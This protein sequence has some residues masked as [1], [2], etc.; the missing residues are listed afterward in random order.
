M[1]TQLPKIAIA[2]GEPAGIGPDITLLC[3][4]NGYPAK[5][6]IIADPEVL[7]QRK[8]ALGLSVD[9]V[10]IN[11]SDQIPEHVPGTA[12]VIPIPSHSP[13][14]AGNLN[15]DNSQYVVS[16]IDTAVDLCKSN[17]FDAMVTA[18]AHKGIIND[19][20]IPFS[21]HTERIAERTDTEQPV[22]ML[23][24]SALRVCLVTTHLPLARVADHITQERIDH[25]IRVMHR[26][27]IKLYGI[28]NPVIG[29]CGLNPHAG[30]GGH[31]G[32]EELD[33]I[34]PALDRLRAEGFNLLGPLPA[35]TAFT[36]QNL[37]K[38]DSIL[39]MYHD[40]G[41]PVIKHSGFGEV[42]NI[43]LGLPIIR[44]SV[45]HGTALDLAATGNANHSS[46]DSAIR[47]AMEFASNQVHTR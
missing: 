16:C 5:L 8:N 30:E 38:V 11:A 7:K 39:A 28:D 46:M 10:E 24:N 32:N 34:C 31:L 12:H 41:L 17:E 3:A 43:T 36:Q 14:E 35:D 15:V 19:A 25:T 40:Q 4:L 45:D 18:P 2:S 20:G 29:V 44:T 42:V 1:E 26:D 27:L 21:G 13:V 33:I 37:G 6:G 47:L 9:I 22:M 23:A